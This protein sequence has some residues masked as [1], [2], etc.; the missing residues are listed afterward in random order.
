MLTRR[1]FLGQ[2]ACG[3]ALTTAQLSGAASPVAPSPNSD[4]RARLSGLLVGSLVGDAF[5][6]PTEF[7][8][9]E[10]AWKLQAGPKQWLP[11]ER[12]DAAG[13]EAARR[14]WRLRGYAPLRPLPEPYGHWRADAPPGT[15]TDDSRWKMILVDAVRAHRERRDGP[16]TERDFARAVLDWPQRRLAKPHPS[17]LPICRE[18]LKEFDYAARWVLGERDVKTARPPARLWVGLTTCCGQMAMPPLAAAF[19][20]RPAEAYKAAHDLSFFDN[21]W[22]RDLNACLVAGLADALVIPP[23]TD[24]R[25]A[26]DRLRRVMRDTDPYGYR[27]V[28]WTERAFDRWSRVAADHVRA[29]RGE[30]AALFQRL[31]AEFA[32]TTKWESQVPCVAVL[33]FAELGEYDPLASMQLCLEWGHDTDSYA[34]L[35]GAFF[36]ALHGADAFPKDA[37]DAV[38]TRLG[39]D[40]SESVD[41]WID[42]L[43]DA[44][45]VVTP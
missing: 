36:G 14:R 43:C 27:D 1:G 17:E 26:W 24:R 18:W 16:M 40:Y 7:Q 39:A 25:A 8:P 35:L 41:E 21:G 45:L 5:G 22:G 34:E 3:A 33:A 28:P 31:D 37:R 10:E 13:L 2:A 23:S 42:V 30:P 11:G 15:L 38:T 9:L 20:G 19:A 12:L 44:P 4:A 6:G 29:S 32:T